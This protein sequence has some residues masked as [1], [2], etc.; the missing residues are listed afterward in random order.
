MRP[1]ADLKRG[2]RP[3]GHLPVLLDA[4][5]RRLDPKAGEI[6]LDATVGLGGHAAAILQRVGPQG[7]LI[8]VDRDA[9]ALDLARA[10]LS[11]VG[12]PFQLARGEYSRLPEFLQQSGRN[13]EGALD[14]LLLDLGVSS[15][16]LD[17]AQRGFSFLRDGPLDMR[18]SQGE[19]PSAF[20]FLQRASLE[21]LERAIREFGEEPAARKVAKAIESAR[22]QQPIETTGA[23]A[24]IVEAVLPRRGQRTHPATRTFQGIRIAVNQ[25]LEHLRR[26]L[27]DLD[28]WIR[29]GGRVVVLSYH[30]LEDRMV[31]ESFRERVAE[32]LYQWALPNPELASDEEVRANPRARSV[33]L[34]SVV[35]STES[36][37][38]K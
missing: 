33:R 6:H 8:G 27:R 14:G 17:S 23:L 24:K 18:M 3:E 29:P 11:A 19:G 35:R 22:R 26:L 38:G 20:D 15:L 2:E 10:R 37:P 4:V 9:E 21:E 13:P 28:R 36:H 31:K 25:E 32:G 1:R 7:L 5:V 12:F 16:Q 30:S 34:R